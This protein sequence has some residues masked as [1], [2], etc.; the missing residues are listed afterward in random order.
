MKT[1]I[2]MIQGDF[3]GASRETKRFRAVDHTQAL[4]KAQAWCASR[5]EEFDIIELWESEALNELT[6]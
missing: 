3:G 1:F 4:T 2:C 6:Q 5:G